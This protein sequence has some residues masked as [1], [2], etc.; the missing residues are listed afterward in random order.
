MTK[1]NFHTHEKREERTQPT[2]PLS[3]AL[4]VCRNGENISL[5]NEYEY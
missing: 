2:L 1:R 4:C 5:L 3:I